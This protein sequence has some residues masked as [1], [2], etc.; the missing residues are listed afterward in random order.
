MP[1][2]PPHTLHV[3]SATHNA[4]L[5]IASL[6]PCKHLQGGFLL[7][8]LLLLLDGCLAQAPSHAC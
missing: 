5:T 7:L 4:G 1:L 8:L 3:Q 2:Q 6:A